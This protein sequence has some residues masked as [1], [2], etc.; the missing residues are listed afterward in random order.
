L[1]QIIVLVNM[2]KHDVLFFIFVAHNHMN[3]CFYRWVMRRMQK[4]FVELLQQS[5]T[6]KLL[7]NITVRDFNLGS[8]FPII[9]HATTNNVV[10]NE[11]NIIEVQTS[12]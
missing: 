11:D 3:D 9:R 12:S 1:S 10:V 4:E 2:K 5:T 8:T 6:G 7:E